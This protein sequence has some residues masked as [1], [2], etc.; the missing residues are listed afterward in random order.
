MQTKRD[1]M[2]AGILAQPDLMADNTNN[3]HTKLSQDVLNK[4]L[5]R[6]S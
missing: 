1:V 3:K 6:N 2:T 5:I 4:R